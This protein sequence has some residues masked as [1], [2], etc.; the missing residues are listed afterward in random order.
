[1]LQPLP[2]RTLDLF[3]QVVNRITLEALG[4]QLHDILYALPGGIFS[5]GHRTSDHR[6]QGYGQVVTLEAHQD[7]FNN[8]PAE[9]AALFLQAGTENLVQAPETIGG[10]VQHRERIG[11]QRW[12]LRHWDGAHP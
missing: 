12:Q 9:L 10:G 11:A 1:L 7:I 4:H 8:R 3:L 5:G 2:S 6:L